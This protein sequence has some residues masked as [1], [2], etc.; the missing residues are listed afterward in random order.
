MI[1]HEFGYDFIKMGEEAHVELANFTTSGK[2]MKGSRAI[3][4]RIDR[5][6]LLLRLFSHLFLR[7]R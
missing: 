5:E 2:K 1:L 7:H 4:N 3:L 6:G